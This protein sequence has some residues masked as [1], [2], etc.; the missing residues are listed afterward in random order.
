MNGM[1][2][3]PKLLSARGVKSLSGTRT[4]LSPILGMTF[5]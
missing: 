5:T 2:S 4:N 1:V 3:A